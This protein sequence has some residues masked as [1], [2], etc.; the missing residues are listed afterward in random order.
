[1]CEDRRYRVLSVTDAAGRGHHL[2]VSLEEI[3]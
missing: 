1:M 2:E 3:R